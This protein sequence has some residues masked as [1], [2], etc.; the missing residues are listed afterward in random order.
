V[1]VEK[2]LVYT[3]RSRFRRYYKNVFKHIQFNLSGV[4]KG[5][6]YRRMWVGLVHTRVSFLKDEVKSR[7][8]SR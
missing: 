2:R 6:Y 1:K 8:V 5:I 3:Q 4:I 7:N